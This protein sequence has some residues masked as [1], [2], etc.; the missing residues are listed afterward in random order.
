MIRIKK[1]DKVQLLAGK[2]KGKIGEVLRILVAKNRAIVDGINL[3]KKHMRK[4]SEQDQ[5][6]IKETPAS[7]NISNL[8]IFCS[9]CNR[10]VRVKSNILKDKSKIRVCTKCKKPI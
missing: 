6:G 5:G 1:G 2:D 10:G 4:R 3:V 8:N 9:Q 7:V